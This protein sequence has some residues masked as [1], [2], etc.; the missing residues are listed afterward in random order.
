MR[1]S[2]PL[3]RARYGRQARG[4]EAIVAGQVEKAFVELR[5][6]LVGSL[7][8]GALLVVDQHFLRHPAEVFEAADQA[9]VGVLCIQ[10]VGAP[11]V[12][13]PRIA[14]GVDD[15]IHF[16]GLPGDRNDHFTPIAFAAAPLARSRSAP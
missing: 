7:D 15:E 8:H 16:G 3:V 12:K 14:Q 13:P 1:S 4:R 5:L 11:E 2:L 10:A 6:A 9:F